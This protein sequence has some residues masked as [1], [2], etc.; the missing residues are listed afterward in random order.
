MVGNGLA[1]STFDQGLQVGGWKLSGEMTSRY[2]GIAPSLWKRIEEQNSADRWNELPQFRE[3][4]VRKIGADNGWKELS[5]PW[6]KEPA[7]FDEP[8]L[9]ILG[10]WTMGGG[11]NPHFALALGEIMVRVKQRNIAWCAYERAAQL[12]DRF[13]PDRTIQQE[14]VKHCRKRQTHLVEEL[15]GASGSPRDIEV[16]LRKQFDLELAYGKELQA[17]YEKHEAEQIARG[18]PLDNEHFYDGFHERYPKIA[19]APGMEDYVKIERDSSNPLPAFAA[20]LGLGLGIGAMM[21][22]FFRA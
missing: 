11:A 8:T 18:V 1:L 14:F 6:H 10:M 15:A 17:A 4:W 21:C 2:E 9:G 3:A 20:C 16:S 5:I 12:S 7:P 19:T 22:A 13:W